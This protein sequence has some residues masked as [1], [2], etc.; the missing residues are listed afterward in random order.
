MRILALCLTICLLTGQAAPALTMDQAVEKALE[1][2]PQIQQFVA[3]ENAA[4]SRSDKAR[5]PFWPSLEVGYSYWTGERDP[6]LDE[7]E[8]STVFSSA[9]YNLFNGGSDWYSLQEANFLA[10]AAGYQRQSV[11]AD[12]VLAVKGAFIEVLRAERNVETEQKSVE[13]L[14]R[15]RHESSLRLREGLIAR[16]D[17][18]RV[19]VE[20]STARQRLLRAKGDL[21][22]ARQNLVR[23]LGL[24]RA[25]V[26]QLDD[27]TLRPEIPAYHFDSLQEEMFFARSELRFLVN[28]LAAD[29]AGRRA[30][31]GDFLPE[32]DLV[33]SYERFGNGTIP[34]TGDNDYDSDSRAMIEASWTLFSGFDTHYEMAAREQE[35]R[36]R[37]QEIRATEEQLTQQLQFALEELKVAE[38]NLAT[39]EI[40]LKQ[41]EENY[42]VNDNRYKARVATTVDLLDAQEFLTRARNEKVKAFYDFHLA[43]VALERVLQRGPRLYE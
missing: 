26:R 3:L 2:N 30:V 10:D 7:D 41:A 19:E 40:G 5:A 15:Q 6:V 28:R 9:R 35:I 17:L 33:L 27:L 18:L 36:A 4:G 11:V 23:T 32:I 22:I 21:A 25:E 31:Q 14:E 34:N 38:G 8:A 12:T 42:R 20:L 24:P 37:I 13:L 43:D 39:A 1:F 29:R 16:N